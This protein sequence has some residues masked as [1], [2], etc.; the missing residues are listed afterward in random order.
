MTRTSYKEQEEEAKEIVQKRRRNDHR[1]TCVSDSRQLEASV[2]EKRANSVLSTLY[3]VPPDTGSLR[4]SSRIAPLDSAS[5]LLVRNKKSQHKNAKSL[6][7]QETQF[8][9][10]STQP[11]L[12]RIF[13]DSATKIRTRFSSSPSTRFVSREPPTI[14][15]PSVSLQFTEDLVAHVVCSVC[16][17]H[18]E[19]TFGTEP[20]LCI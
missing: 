10:L 15:L 16:L 11:T 8:P 18:L 2:V 7:C 4:K 19:P 12:L 9:T 17:W 20:T 1:L 14:P 3:D 13:L 6:L 5:D